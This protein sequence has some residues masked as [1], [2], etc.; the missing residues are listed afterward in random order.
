MHYIKLC[1][2]NTCKIWNEHFLYLT[3]FRQESNSNLTAY[4]IRNS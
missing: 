2:Q 3:A 1:K 4:N